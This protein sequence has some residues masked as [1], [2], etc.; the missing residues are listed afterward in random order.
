MVIKKR[1]ISEEDK[2]KRRTKIL[3]TAWRLFKQ[4]GG[5]LPT[6]SGIAGK[7]GMSKGTVYL[8]FKTKEEIFLVLYLQKVAEWFESSIAP[9]K[10]RK[11]QLTAEEI[12]RVFTNHVIKNPDVL[13]MSSIAKSVIEENIGDEALIRAKIASAGLLKASGEI[14]SAS[15]PG[16]S[17]EKGAEITLWIIS[18]ITGLWQFAS[19]PPHISKIIKKQNLTVLEPDFAE[20]VTAAV[21]ALIRGS[22]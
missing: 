12:A 15:F 18:L 1:A 11:G 8:Y 16:T 4:K 21:A 9:V 14:F 22:I 13:M 20:S 6:V 5:L 19:H 10:E 7:A 17:K 3:N 2:L